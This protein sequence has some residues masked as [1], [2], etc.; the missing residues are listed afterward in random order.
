[1]FED[2]IPEEGVVDTAAMVATI[3]VSAMV[4]TVVVSTVVTVAVASG[5]G[6]GQ[7]GNEKGN[8]SH[9]FLTRNV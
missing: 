4:A 9:L 8:N 1:M 6:K 7:N 5:G 3:V 2:G